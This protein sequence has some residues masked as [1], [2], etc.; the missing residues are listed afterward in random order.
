VGWPHCVQNQD[1]TQL[2]IDRQ[3]TLIAFE[4]MN[5]W[6]ED[7]SFGLHVFHKNNEL[8]G[9]SSVLHAMQL[10]GITGEYGRP[11][12]AAVIGFGATGRGWHGLQLGTTHL[13]CG[14]DVHRGQQHS[15]LRRGPQSVAAVELRYLGD[16]RSV[17]AISEDRARRPWGVGP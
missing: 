11:L 9:Y 4:A 8:A 16:Q 12:R 3:L 10:V 17:A 1:I 6:T 5:H 2:G 7:G 14:P 15:L 13:I